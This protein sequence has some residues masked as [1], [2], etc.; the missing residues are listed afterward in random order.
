MPEVVGASGAGIFLMHTRGRPQEM[1]KDTAYDDILAEIRKFLQQ[2]VGR[3]L[4]C[5]IEKDR[6][7]IDP[8]VGFAKDLNGNLKILQNLDF[9]TSLGFP[10]LLG[11]SRKSFIGRILGAPMPESRL[12][13]SLATVAMGVRAGVRLFRVH[14]VA[15]SRDTALTAWAICSQGMREAL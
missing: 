5:G 13:G 4:A 8:G 9:L 3:A 1:Q 6:I 11:T 2:A 7:A 10:V 15:P 14:D 12:Y